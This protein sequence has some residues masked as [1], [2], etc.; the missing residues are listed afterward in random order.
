MIDNGIDPQAERTAVHTALTLNKVVE[1]Y[2]LEYLP[3][4]EWN[5]QNL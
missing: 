3:N 2:E 4:L 5:T 1:L